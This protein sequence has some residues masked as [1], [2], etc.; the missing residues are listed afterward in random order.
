MII[1][2]LL[3]KH[4]YY[5]VEVN[6]DEG[7]DVHKGKKKTKSKKPAKTKSFKSQKKKNRKG[8]ERQINSFL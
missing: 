7:W 8:E 2:V 6:S 1:H 3:Q 5:K 4:A